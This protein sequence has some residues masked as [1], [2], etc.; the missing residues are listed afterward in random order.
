MTDH[1]TIPKSD[2]Q[3][4]FSMSGIIGILG[5]SPF[6]KVVNGFSLEIGKPLIY[7]ERTKFAVFTDKMIIQIKGPYKRVRFI[8]WA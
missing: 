3:S 8:T 5:I 7:I 2:F 1:L 6:S 4:E